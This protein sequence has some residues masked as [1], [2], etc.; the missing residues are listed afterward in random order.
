MKSRNYLL[1][2]ILHVIP[3]YL[4]SQT[5]NLSFTHLGRSEGLSQTFITS[6]FQDNRG[7]MWF[8]SYDG[9]NKYDGYKITTYKFD[10]RNKN[11][12]SNN[13]IK[14]ILE[15]SKG[16]LWVATG[17]GLNRFNRDTETF[18]KF[19]HT[20]APNSILSN[21]VKAITRDKSGNIW[22]GCADD[23]KN[24]GGLQLFDIKQ[25]TF[26]QY[27]IPASINIRDI[28]A[29]SQ[30]QLWIAHD[31]GISVFDITSR[32]VIQDF[33][34]NPADKTSLSKD[35]ITI[36][37]EDSY[38]NIWV[39]TQNS[40]L[41]LYDKKTNG[42]K[43]F[44]KQAG[45]QNS[46][47]N[48]AIIAIMEDR[49][50]NLWIGT[51]NGGIDILNQSTG[52][53]SNYFQ[54]EANPTGLQSNSIHALYT[55]V[56]GNVWVGTQ[57]GIDFLDR[58]KEKFNQIKKSSFK[59]G[60]NCNTVFCIR[61]GSDNNIL[62]A[63]D[64]GGLNVLN[65]KTG[66]ITKMQHE[67]GNK[68][69][70]CGDHVISVLEDSYQNVWIGTWGDGL[71]VYNKKK[72]TYKHYK[73]NPAD[74]YSLGGI[75][76]WTIYEDRDKN[77]WIGT[78]WG[79]LSLYD[80]HKDRFITYRKDPNDP[81]S[82]NNN[83]VMAIIE[84]REGN[85]WVGT[86]GGGLCMLNR[87]TNKFTTYIHKENKNS[88]NDNSIN[89]IYEDSDG[90]LWISTPTGL[91]HFNR[92]TN[93][94]TLYNKESGLHSDNVQEVI[95]DLKG[96]LWVN[97]SDGIS[98]LDPK[99]KTIKNYTVS[100]NWEGGVHTAF[101]KT[102][103][104]I[105]LGSMYGLVQFYP[106][107]LVDVEYDPPV[108][109]TSFQILNE[110]VPI[111]DSLNPNSPLV[112]TI[113]ET[114]EIAIPYSQS[115]ISFEFA[116]LNYTST[117]KKIYSYK[118]EG[119]D[120]DWNNIEEK[121]SATYTN[122]DPGEYILKIKSLNNEGKW[123]DKVTKLKIV[124]LPPFWMT[125]AFR[126][127][128]LTI[129]VGSAALFMRWRIKSIQH[130]KKI[131]EQQ[132]E[133]R[134]ERLAQSTEQERK[135][136]LEAETAKLDAEKANQA[137]SI[138]LAT[139]SHE[140]RTPM[141]GVIG[142][143]AL[144]A[145][146][147]LTS[148]QRE[149]TDTITNCGESLLTVINDILDFSKIESG[150]MELEAAD[151]DLRNCIE[152]V[153]DIFANKASE[154]VIDLLYQVDHNV[155]LQIIGDEMRLK[156][157]LTNLIGNAM[158]FTQQGEVFVGVHFMKSTGKGLEL[159]FEVRDTG[160]GIAEDKLERLFKAFSQVDSST[161]RKYGGTGLGLAISEKLVTLMGGRIKVVS[162]PEL[163]SS[164]SFTISVEASQQPLRTYVHYNIPAM[165]GKRVLA[166]DDNATNR[167]ILKKQLEQWKLIPVLAESS[168]DAIAILSDKAQTFD[169]IITDLQMPD[170]DGVQ[171]ARVIQKQ[172]P[173][174]PIILLSSIGD[175]SHKHHPNLFNS[176][177]TKPIK[178]NVLYKHIIAGLNRQ[179]KSVFE[180]AMVKEKLPS[181]FSE[182]HPMKFL[183]AED[184]LI[185]QKLIIH[186]LNRLGY[187]PDMVNNGLEAVE[188]MRN[189]S[190]DIILMDIQ[191]PE[192]DGL[193]ATE[194]IRKQNI[195]QPVIIALTANTMQGDQEECIN[196]GMNDYISKP[197]KLEELVSLLEKWA[198][199]QVGA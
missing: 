102:N 119:F 26:T 72:K 147:S 37:F 141:N 46:I 2:F 58:D 190:Y 81:H 12:L 33:S 168:K 117:S 101:K 86:A 88:I 180:E 89:N 95:A 66:E 127:S 47:S 54:D 43:H 143:S 105:L 175:E 16:N 120:R 192:M 113:T 90:N 107:K 59:D 111:A 9:L 82:L 11:S 77:I 145:E 123:S 14:E 48:N 132:V 91:N 50:K 96:K 138:F 74:P 41:E 193:E 93:K 1:I 178:Q 166:V 4:F 164:F 122:L 139:M 153:L 159:E 149:L 163:G 84:D 196:A 79:G 21:T 8:G 156:Q 125:W 103:G 152:N 142:M 25:K 106:D 115:V 75:Q 169:L 162:K 18:E 195:K 13:N 171:L 186:I 78:F 133:E 191:M 173:S 188:A 98:M 185:N 197:V 53:F 99:T 49:N 38:H 194:I 52:I 114:K 23:G 137:K 170:M 68:N 148:Q 189:N 109:F 136:R 160:I 51:E 161:T 121:H 3:F 144:L 61:Q 83:V 167:T 199:Q 31:N 158:K 29:D 57:K 176:M 150:N 19:I 179:D 177:L 64:G 187:A 130:Q 128:V 39:G 116:S 30:N 45:K 198:V 7:F 70:I 118:L 24:K 87:K 131:L 65:E 165:Q 34:H 76:P 5:K 85:L 36:I 157:V 134:T 73:H 154:K 174:M 112:K 63:T 6:I 69:S 182:Q 124:V 94:F 32:K 42:Y 28:S 15:D 55:D 110:E 40:G 35:L 184:H 20:N 172:L 146:T 62:I 181:N 155:P 10:S 104:E 97:T 60:L 22:I 92:K 108:V 140:I 183:V 80:R 135:A 67:P 71:T 100:E 17:Y 151:F 44:R 56:K 129:I 27:K 126:I